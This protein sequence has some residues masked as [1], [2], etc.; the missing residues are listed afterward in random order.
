MLVALSDRVAG[1]TEWLVVLKS[2]M[3]VARLM[4]DAE[5]SVFRTTLAELLF[6][7][8]GRDNGERRREGSGGLAL[9]NLGSFKDDSTPDAWE[10]SGWV[11]SYSLYL[12]ERCAVLAEIR[13]DPQAEPPSAPSASRAWNPQQLL[14]G[15][16]RLQSLLRRL[17]DALP[18][19]ARLHPVAAAAAGDLVRDTRLLFRSVSDAIINLVDKFFDMPPHD[20]S[21]ALDMYKRATRQVADLNGAPAGAAQRRC[22]S[23]PLLSSRL[24]PSPPPPPPSPQPRCP[25]C[26][27][28]LSWLLS[29]PGCPTLSS[30]P[31]GSS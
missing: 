29:A 5:G 28:T 27:P 30:R 9:F 25:A 23:P 12:E 8:R 14:L 3:V 31:P 15:L 7:G 4:R 20:K 11:R 18:K 17:T 19:L 24:T 13:L 1:A 6:G 16:P 2:L 21:A 26:A 10:L 22:L